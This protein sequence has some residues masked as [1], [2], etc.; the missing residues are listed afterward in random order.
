MMLIFTAAPITRISQTESASGILLPPM[1]FDGIG[2][3]AQLL[4]ILTFGQDRLFGKQSHTTRLVMMTKWFQQTGTHQHGNVV[5][6]RHIFPVTV[7]SM[8]NRRS[9]IPLGY[10]INF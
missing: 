10:H 6:P 5:H 3:L 1:P 8:A 4:F 7:F 2:D 9:Y